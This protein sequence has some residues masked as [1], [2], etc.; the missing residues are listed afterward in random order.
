MHDA[1]KAIE[2]IEL[3]AAKGLKLSIDDFGTGYSCLSYLKKFKVSKLK[4]DQSFVHDIGG[5]DEDRTIVKAIIQMAHSLGMATI[6][7]GVETQEQLAFLSLHGCAEFQGYLI[8]RPMD[9]NDFEDFL[10]KSKDRWLSHPSGARSNVTTG[11]V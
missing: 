3:F 1:K 9:C 8:N 4:I 6:A 7:E 10:R 5:M 11:Y 2:T